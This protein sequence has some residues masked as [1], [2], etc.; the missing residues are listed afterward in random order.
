MPEDFKELVDHC[1]TLPLAE[2]SPCYPYTGFVLNISSCTKGHR[3]RMDLKSCG[4]FPFGKWNGGEL[5]LFELKLV[6]DLQPGD[7][8][9]FPS[10][11]ITHFNLHFSG[12]HFSLVFQTDR[13]IVSWSE[14]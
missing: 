11:D 2:G 1:E 14:T 13:E 9:I 4:I 8:F 5:C 6:L 7:L 10:A 12:I 3:D